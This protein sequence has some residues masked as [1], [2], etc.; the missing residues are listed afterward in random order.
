MI[1]PPRNRASIPSPGCGIIK[2]SRMI[3]DGFVLVSQW[4][5]IG[6]ASSL[7]DLGVGS[8]SLVYSLL[9]GVY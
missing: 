7:D 3:G 8:S 4:S 9:E 6:G 1:M 5:S 2:I